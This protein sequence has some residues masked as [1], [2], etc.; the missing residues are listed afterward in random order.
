MSPL[1][2]T[3]MCCVQSVIDKNC[4]QN[5]K[6]WSDQLAL[7]TFQDQD[8]G[9]HEC[10]WLAVLH[11]NQ[12]HGQ[13]IKNSS[14]WEAN[15]HK[16]LSELVRNYEENLCA[17]IK[18]TVQYHLSFPANSIISVMLSSSML[19]MFTRSIFWLPATWVILN[20]NMQP[21]APITHFL[22]ALYSAFQCPAYFVY[23]QKLIQE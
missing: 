3:P 19:T 18:V 22:C 16:R 5:W 11:I 15:S 8:Y 6:L 10:L 21:Q 2:G 17:C 1:D 14:K 7:W 12:F 9:K 4:A 20:S 23:S 13:V